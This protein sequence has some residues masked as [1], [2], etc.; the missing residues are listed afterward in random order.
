M[1]APLWQALGEA[2]NPITGNCG[3]ADNDWCGTQITN[4][5]GVVLVGNPDPVRGPAKM[6][7]YTVNYHD[8]Q[9]TNAG[10]IT[11]SDQRACTSTPGRLIARAKTEW[12]LR[13]FMLVDDSWIGRFPKQDELQSWINDP[14][15]GAALDG[16]SG[17]QFHHGYDDHRTEQGSAPLYT[18]IDDK[19]PW[20]KLVN[21]AT[22]TEKKRFVK[23][24]LQRNHAY[25]W[26]LHVVHDT[27]P[28]SGLVELWIDGEAIAIGYHTDTMY[29]GTFNYLIACIYRR[30]S[31]GSPT[32]QD[33]S[34]L[35]WPADAKAGVKYPALFTPKKGARVY[36]DFGMPQ[37][38]Y[39]GGLCVGATRDAVV[40]LYPTTRGGSVATTTT[41]AAPA[42]FDPA[43][44]S[45][46]PNAGAKQ[47][48]ATRDALVAQV[49]AVQAQIDAINALLSKGAYKP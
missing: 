5:Q 17:V 1:T 31:I 45:V 21:G 6:F 49:A 4:P 36:D 19:G 26:L 37:S 34:P 39:I 42:N 32:Y 29:P 7:M 44:P 27:D 47:L 9:F 14:V 10:G 23:Q 38:H 16:G 35:V 8:G 30:W 20:C 48:M 18:G 2:K 40:N 3:P 46:N 33:G 28:A 12:W 11:Y 24:P 13:W 15:N 41:P 22:S 43:Q 25:E